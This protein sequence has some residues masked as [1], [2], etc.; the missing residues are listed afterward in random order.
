[1]KAEGAGS[2]AVF[3]EC[4]TIFSP[5]HPDQDYEDNFF[6]SSGNTCTLEWVIPLAMYIAKHSRRYCVVCLSKQ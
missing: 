3:G 5:K 4:A 6:T 2:D 1:M